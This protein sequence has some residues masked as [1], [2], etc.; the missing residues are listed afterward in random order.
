MRYKDQEDLKQ[1]MIHLSLAVSV[2]A[3][4]ILTV[5]IVSNY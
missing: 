1:W 4:V 5:L 3:I 2:T